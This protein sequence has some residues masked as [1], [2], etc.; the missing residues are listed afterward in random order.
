[1]EIQKKT[2]VS[3][4]QSVILCTE[5]LAAFYKGARRHSVAI[6]GIE[7]ILSRVIKLK[8]PIIAKGRESGACSPRKNFISCIRI[9]HLR[10]H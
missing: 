8:N 7:E 5:N 2:P 3:V 6:G 1:M 4:T 9:A 10:L